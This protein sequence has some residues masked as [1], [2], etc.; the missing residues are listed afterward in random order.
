MRHREP[1]IFH[2]FPQG[3]ISLLE[4]PIALIVLALVIIMASRAFMSA[5]H[6][7]K[8]S[9]LANQATAFASAKLN[10]LES[11]PV[12]L[13]NDGKDTVMSSTG[14]SFTRKWTVSQPISGSNAKSVQVEVHWK[15]NQ[16]NDSI[17]VSSFIR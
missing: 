2:R 4:I 11:T 9:H 7:Q 17:N 16:Q 1:P 12:S 14:L 15:L 6:V 13:I 3:G 8:D 10:E 5:N